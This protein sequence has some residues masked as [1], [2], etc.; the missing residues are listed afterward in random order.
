MGWDGN[1]RSV[2][3]LTAVLVFLAVVG[4]TRLIEAERQRRRVEGRADV[5][6][7][8]NE[9]LTVLNQIARTM[10]STLDHR[11]AILG[12]QRQIAATFGSPVVCIVEHSDATGE[13][14]PRLAEGC[15]VDTRATLDAVPPVFSE[16]ATS[17]GHRL[18]Q[19]GDD[20]EFLGPNSGSGIYARLDARD[21]VIGILA[22]EDPDPERFRQSELL[23]LDGLADVIALTLDNAR[24]FGRLRALGAESERSRIARDLHDRLGQWLTYLS[25]ELERLASAEP[26]HPE[27]SRLHDDALTAL[28]ELRETLRQLRTAVTTERRLDLVLGEFAARFGE[29]SGVDMTL[30]VTNPGEHLSVGVENELLRITQEALNNIDKHADATNVEVTW[31]VGDGDAT[32]TITDD[33]MGFETWGSIRDNAYGLVGMRERAD[34]ID[35]QLDI[36]S[37]PGAGTTITVELTTPEEQ[38]A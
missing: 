3:I 13:W 35:A 38:L 34:V 16:V 7:E 21:R 36:R 6:H 33:G 25:L 28:D 15:V 5:L 27:I 11:E 29:R 12:A 20:V 23:L 24:W 10:P 37:A 4:R 17:G 31:T 32:L 30:T 8:T 9:L 2:A 26:A 19:A 22:I 14:T 18:V 1:T